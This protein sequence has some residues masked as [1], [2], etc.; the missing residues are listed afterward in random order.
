MKTVLTI[1]MTL[2][3]FST[4]T[5]A[6]SDADQEFASFAPLLLLVIIGVFIFW[7]A[8]KNKKIKEQREQEILDDIDTR[9]KILENKQDS[10]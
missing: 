3:L 10:L 7:K 4:H 6:Q 2:T 1:G 9:L 8:N 5:F